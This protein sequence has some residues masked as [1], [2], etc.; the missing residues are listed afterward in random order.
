VIPC[1]TSPNGFCVAT[2]KTITTDQGEEW[3][4]QPASF[5]QA[6]DGKTRQQLDDAAVT[7]RLQGVSNELFT[8][9]CGGAGLAG[10]ACQ[11]YMAAGGENPITGGS[12]Q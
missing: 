9:G 11:G 5:E 10:I 1:D 6:V 12:D 7:A 4:L 2:D 3:V 8:A